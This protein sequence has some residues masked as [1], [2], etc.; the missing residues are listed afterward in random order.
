MY[1]CR[2]IPYKNSAKTK[3]RYDDRYTPR[4][5]DISLRSAPERAFS[6]SKT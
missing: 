3:D 5:I 2:D 1:Y 6:L 4:K